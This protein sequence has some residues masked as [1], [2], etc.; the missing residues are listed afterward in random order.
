MDVSGWSHVDDPLS[1]TWRPSVQR[2]REGAGLDLK[3]VFQLFHPDTATTLHDMRDGVYPLP[4]QLD[5]P[6]AALHLL[7]LGAVLNVFAL[8]HADSIVDKIEAFSSSGAPLF[9]AKGDPKVSRRR[10]ALVS[11]LRRPSLQMRKQLRLV[12]VTRVQLCVRCAMS[13]SC[14]R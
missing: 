4:I 13:P 3:T 9:V 6:V 11:S 1:A 10:S 14:T 7:A 2:D 5:E 12:Y 8:E